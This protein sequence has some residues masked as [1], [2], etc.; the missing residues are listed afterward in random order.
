MSEFIDSLGWKWWQMLWLYCFV[1]PEE[2]NAHFL[3]GFEIR[4]INVYLDEVLSGSEKDEL[5]NC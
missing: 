1:G 3:L 2:R 4:K 5:F